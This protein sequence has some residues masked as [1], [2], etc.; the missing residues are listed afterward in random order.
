MNISIN[1]NLGKEIIKKIKKNIEFDINIMDL[2]GKI[3][4]STD[5]DRMSQIHNGAVQVIKT[6]KELIIYDKDIKIFQGTMP[7]VNLPIFHHNVLKGV[8]GVSGDPN[9]ILSMTGLIRAFVE[10]ILDQL[11]IHK[12]EHFKERQWNYWL[13]QL[14]HPTATDEFF[15]KR[16]AI[17]T[18]KSNM[19]DVWKVIVI[20]G[21]NVQEFLEKIRESL[22]QEQ[23]LF[24]LPFSTK[25][26]IIT[27]S[28][29]FKEIDILTQKLLSVSL[30]MVQI[31]I[32]EANYGV[33]GIRTSYFQAKQAINFKNKTG[34]ISNSK[35][36]KLERLAISI[37]KEEYNQIC[38][39][40][41]KDLK[42][43]NII[44][45]QTI[46]TYFQTNFS[47]KQTAKRLNIHR[48]TLQYRLDQVFNKVGLNPRRFSH[49]FILKLIICKNSYC[50]N[51]QNHEKNHI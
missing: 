22:K 6:K 33:K 2:T 29:Q 12:N 7:G 36:W 24:I 31:G 13:Q 25:E 23:I 50:A 40:Y 34:T 44:Y 15:L 51:A 14:L 48:N 10:I 32:G 1:N 30:G 47:V 3:V 19:D 43:L 17:Y 8:V 27:I 4:S 16:E 49:A 28:S 5:K 37:S 38:E 11:H 20:S 18:L 41:E 45:Y 26:I 35:D 21:E 39:S 46:N 9:E 42:S